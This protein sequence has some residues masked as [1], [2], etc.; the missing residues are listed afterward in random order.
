MKRFANQ[1]PQSLRNSTSRSVKSAMSKPRFGPTGIVRSEMKNG[2]KITSAQ[3]TG[4]MFAA[5][6]IMFQAG[7]RYE[8]HDD[9][10]ATHFLRL[11]STGGGCRATAFSKLRVL[12]QAGAYITTT[13]DRQTVAYTL[14][15]PLHM[16]SD[17]KYYLLDTAV[18][19]CYH[20]WEI[21]DLKPIVRGDL[22]R[23]H[24]EQRVID[25]IQKA[26]W[27]G[28]LAN[29]VY[30]E[31]DRIDS[32]DG[33]KLRNYVSM[34][35]IPPMCSVASVG[36]PF[37]ETMKIAE[38]IERSSEEHLPQSQKVYPRMGHEYYDL[39]PD[40]DTW[41]A[42]A[43]PSCDSWDFQGVFKHAIIASACGTDNMQGGMTSMNRIPQSPLGLISDKD[44]HT[45]CRAFNI[46]YIDTGLF[47]ILAKTSSCSAYRISKMI[48]E[49]LA[50]VGELGVTQIEEGKERLLLNLAIHDEDCVRICEGLA[51]QSLYNSQ[52]DCAEN[53]A[54]IIQGI[55]S[56]EVSA[57]AKLL[58][59][60]CHQMAI[61]IVGDIGVVPVDQDIF[62]R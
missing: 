18:G 8:T 56:E 53:S 20:D 22:N 3:D 54:K 2:I 7:S 48:A 59:S 58:S 17:L 33:E 34:N 12:Q 42:V 50:R 5:C 38:K 55:S 35:F 10:G 24:P 44:V 6:T 39:G 15:C 47:G 61:A 23:I 21:T 51:L 9:L 29:S 27:A 11:A 19:C 32:M 28:P 37:E 13:L 62:R 60:K 14:R 30:C 25:L 49:F 31:E 45:D 41:I 4:F 43:V 36:V 57:T 52:I 26:A 40:S 46:S 1:I 16:F